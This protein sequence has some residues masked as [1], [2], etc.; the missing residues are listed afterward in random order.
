MSLPLGLRRARDCNICVTSRKEVNLG[1]NSC[2]KLCPNFE[3]ISWTKT[4]LD[5]RRHGAGLESKMSL[6]WTFWSTHAFCRARLTWLRSLL[7]VCHK[8][9][10]QRLKQ[11]CAK[12]TWPHSEK[13]SKHGLRSKIRGPECFKLESTC[14]QRCYT[15]FISGRNRLDRYLDLNLWQIK[16]YLTCFSDKEWI[17]WVPLKSRPWQ[18][19]RCLAGLNPTWLWSQVQYFSNL[20]LAV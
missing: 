2:Q 11:R 5:I 14:C 20:P 3:R 9:L 6:L 8:T 12:K 16:T 10:L 1:E 15:S 4:A 7:Y 13:K 18:M 17:L 19:L